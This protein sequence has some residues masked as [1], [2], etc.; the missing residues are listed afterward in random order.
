MGGKIPDPVPIAMH[1]FLFAARYAGMLL[2]D[3]CR[4]V[5]AEEPTGH[6]AKV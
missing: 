2:Q 3:C 5:F 4:A 1:N 6:T